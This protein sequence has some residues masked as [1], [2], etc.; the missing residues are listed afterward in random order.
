MLAVVTLKPS[1][2]GRTY[3]LPTAQD[4]D[5]VRSASVSLAVLLQ[6]SRQDGGATLT[7]VPD[8]PLP[9]IGTLGFRVQRYGMLQ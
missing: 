8:E 4:Y 9:A 1:E 3:R 6:K 2:Q 7:P 5:A